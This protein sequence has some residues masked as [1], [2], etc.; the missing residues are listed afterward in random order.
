M[1]GHVRPDWVVVEVRC[2]ERTDYTIRS[3]LEVTLDS[4]I[5]TG[6]IFRM[7]Y[8]CARPRPDSKGCLVGAATIDAATSSG[9][10]FDSLN[11]HQ[12]FR[13]ELTNMRKDVDSPKMAPEAHQN[14][15]LVE[16]VGGFS[17]VLLPHHWV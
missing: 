5:R 4:M 8:D 3:G 16:H 10:I 7:L 12:H 11:A 14:M 2:T 9:H 15:T 13:A 6:M 1:F 17:A